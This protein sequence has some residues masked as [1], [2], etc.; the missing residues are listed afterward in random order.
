MSEANCQTSAKYCSFKVTLSNEEVQKEVCRYCGR[1]E[2]WKLKP[3]GQLV[4]NSDYLKA[5]IRDFCQPGSRVYEELYGR[6]A[7]KDVAEASSLEER[8]KKRQDEL[9][10]EFTKHVTAPEKTT[11]M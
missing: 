9:G 3:G 7:V 2:I 6:K 5:H 4:D 11:F 8:H 10:E 1:R